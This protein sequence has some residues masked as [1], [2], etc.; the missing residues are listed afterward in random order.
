MSG[1]YETD[2]SGSILTT[3]VKYTEARDKSWFKPMNGSPLFQGF[4]EHEFY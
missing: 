4:I 2:L 3:Q 1:L